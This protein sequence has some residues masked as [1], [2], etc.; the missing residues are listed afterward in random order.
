MFNTV[1]LKRVPKNIRFLAFSYPLGLAFF[2]FFRLILTISNSERLFTLPP[3]ERCHLMLDAFIMGF[4]FDTVISAYIL[5]LPFLIFSISTFFSVKPVLADKA[6]IY[7]AGILYSV[8]FIICSADIPYFR[9]YFSR[10]NT[11]VFN[12]M[13]Q[14]SFMFGM[15]FHEISYFLYVILFIIMAALFWY[16]FIKGAKRYVLNEKYQPERKLFLRNSL[17]FIVT[18]PFIF[19]GIRGRIEQKSPIRV[20]TAYFSSYSF[21]NQLGLNPVFTFL[22]SY[23]DDLEGKTIQLHLMDDKTALK[24]TINYLNAVNAPS[25]FP[26]SRYSKTDGI[27]RNMNVVLV[28]MESMSAEKMKRYGNEKH[29]TPRLDSLASVSVCFDNFYSAGIHTY[30]GIYSTLYSYPALLKQHPM[31]QTRI[32]KM[33][34]FPNILSNAGYSTVFFTTH[35][36]QFDNMSGFMYSNGF[37]RIVSQKDYPQQWVVGPT[38]VP[39]HILFEQAIPVLNGLSAKNKPF[40]AALLTASDHGPYHIPDNIPF[41]PKSQ[42]MQNNIVE[43]ADW[44]IGHFM[45]MAS[46]QDW[47]K[48]TI[49]VFVADHGAVV[50]PVYDMPLSFN[51]SPFIIF[52]PSIFKS[53]ASL[54][55]PGGQ[56]DVFPT[57]MYL[58]NIPYVNNTMGVDLFSTKRQYIYF[59][60]DDKIGCVD[61]KYFYIYRMTGEESLYDYTAGSTINLLKEKPEKAKEMKEYS[62]SM[63]QSAQFLLRT[64]KTGGL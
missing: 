54:K 51:H 13:D 62:F 28:I 5:L 38:G 22:R 27:P 37:Q 47:F 14:K 11:A 18:V 17:Y 29:L 4:R 19:L 10:L 40:F 59:S 36:E 43:Y 21:P 55:E 1:P 41:K 34:G 25:A 58:L 30:N 53:P 52:A 63:L 56:I 61:Q 49:F 39:D 15:V 2:F 32:P 20:G 48:N 7:L 57:I 60:C 8:S 44:S 46:S 42:G 3:S 64:E 33:S 12:W 26:I 50:N 16:L 6:A 9:Y 24:N 23:L 31:K 35:D 45:S